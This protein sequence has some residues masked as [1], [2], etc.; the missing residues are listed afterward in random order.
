MGI[1]G[2]QEALHDAARGWCD[3]HLPLTVA[4]SCLDG[5]QPD[6][7]VVGKGIVAQGWVGLP[8]EFGLL[9]AAIV[10]EELGRACAP[11]SALPSMAAVALL[12]R[13]GS[14]GRGVVD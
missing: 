5:G 8:A 11:G 4:R 1:G 7:A 6:L 3:R 9:E 12:H 13:L 10:V 14:E 2:E